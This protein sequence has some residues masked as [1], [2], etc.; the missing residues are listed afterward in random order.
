M[1]PVAANVLDRL[2]GDL[3]AV[4]PTAVLA[5]VA[6]A[7][8]GRLLG[9]RR[10][11]AATVAAAAVGWI[12]GVA[13]AVVVASERAD[14]SRGFARDLVLF[15]L[16]GTMAGSV[17]AEFV[18][19]P[20]LV[21]RTRRGM[22]SFPHPVRAFRIR[23]RRVRRYA[24]ITRVAV[25]HGLGPSLGFV[26]EDQTASGGRSSLV[27]RFRRAL[28]EAGGMFVK[29]G[30]LLSTRTDLFSPDAA[31][32]LA[33]LQDDV[34]P[35]R[36]ADVARLLERELGAPLETVFAEFDW[37]PLASA[38]IGQV[39]RAT[40][41]DGSPVVVKVQRP[42]VDETVE[43]DL[44]VLEEIGANAERRTTWGAEHQASQVVREFATRLREEL[45]F[46]IEARNA[47][48]IAANLGPESLVRV[49]YVYQELNTARVL[50]TEH[51]DGVSVRN[52]AALEAMGVD[53]AK[54]ADALLRSFVEQMLQD[55]VFHADPHPGNVLALSDGTLALVDFGATG[56]LDPVQQGALR[57]LLGAL[58]RRDAD[59][60]VQ[61][62]LQVAEL[63][64]GVDVVDFERGVER[65]MARH[66]TPGAAA[67]V[68]MLN[69][70]LRLFFDFGVIL[71]G[72]WTTFFRALITLDGTLTTLAPGFSALDA[73]EEMAAEWTRANFSVGSAQQA[74]R[75][76]LMRMIPILRRLPRHIDRTFT[77][78]GR[79]GLRVR[80]SHF[81]DD[82]DVRVVTRLVNRIA[83]ALLAGALGLLSVGLLAIEGGPVLAGETTL[84]RVL[85]AVGLFAS[86]ALTLRIV[87]AVMRD[88]V[89]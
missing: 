18:T 66:L 40:L 75:D 80:V 29:L 24:E 36:Q 46:R 25:R 55:G 22:A 68:A 32:E 70:L 50:V 19:R 47:E 20:G 11:P 14:A 82:R 64:R 83:L 42:G 2:D 81:G 84:F 34:R 61:S 23:A 88:G 85:G 49:P 71:P 45:D 27:R 13:V 38:S 10:S 57:D 56:R 54:L 59:A 89:D 26:R 76:E 28:E 58:R 1:L 21:A 6:S 51:V 39:Y 9:V 5:L 43:V 62:V 77:T 73:A 3:W 31:A 53:R 67:D 37:R 33:Q 69:A 4:V 16:L 8:L 48:T 65:F 30:Q 35:A 78:V 41:P 44:S 79:D 7:V 87:V 12:L 15:T 52:A 74:A 63:R 17:W 72:E 86:T 60:V